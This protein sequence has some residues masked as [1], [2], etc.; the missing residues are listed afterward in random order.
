[1]A[2]ARSVRSTSSG[3]VSA[4]G[5]GYVITAS[6][7]RRRER[8]APAAPRAV[9]LPPRAAR[10]Q[11]AVGSGVGRSQ[12]AP[13]RAAPVVPAVARRALP[14]AGIGEPPRLLGAVALV[15]RVDLAGGLSDPH[16]R[17]PQLADAAAGDDEA[18]GHGLAPAAGLPD[19][20]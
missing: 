7:P 14:A 8:A 2:S 11:L 16:E 9:T 20:G 15:E 4:S 6:L 10:R 1:M 5:R 18:G 17:G 3:S 12:P 13:A 19:L